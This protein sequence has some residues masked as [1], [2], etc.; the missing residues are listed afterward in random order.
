MIVLGI[1]TS[2]DETAVAIVDHQKNILAHTL[3]SQIELHKKFGGVV[4]E[5]AAR[6]HVEVLDELI[7]QALKEANLKFKEIDFVSLGEIKKD[8]NAWIIPAYASV[9]F[10]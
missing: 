5:L 10:K 2:C 8:D 6:G 7:L 9:V 1:E 4:P 3:K